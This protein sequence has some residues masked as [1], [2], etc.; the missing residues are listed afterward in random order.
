MKS[1]PNYTVRIATCKKT[2]TCNRSSAH[3]AQGCVCHSMARE[4]WFD[5]RSKGVGESGKE[6]ERG[7]HTRSS[8]PGTLSRPTRPTQRRPDGTKSSRH[9]WLHHSHPVGPRGQALQGQSVDRKDLDVRV[10]TRC[11]QE[12]FIAASFLVQKRWPSLLRPELKRCP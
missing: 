10:S 1:L 2:S 7:G 11:A 8:V 9:V 4:W 6:W 3:T 12:K 5:V